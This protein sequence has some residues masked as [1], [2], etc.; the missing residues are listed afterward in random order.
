AAGWKVVDHGHDYRLEP[1]HPPDR[2]VGGVRRYGA[3]ATVPSR[4]GEPVVAPATVVLVVG[5]RADRITSSAMALQQVAPPGTQLAVVAE[6]PDHETEALL[7]AL[8]QSVEVVRLASAVGLAACWNSGLRRAVGEIVVLVGPDVE[9]R[10]D[11][12][13]PVVEALADETV[14]V[15]GATGLSSPDMRRWEA[16][17]GPEVDAVDAELLAFR[18]ADAVDGGPLE[19]RFN[20]ARYLAVWWSLVLRDR[21]T[22][23]PPRRALV[24]PLAVERS[25]E[26]PAT[27]ERDRATRRDFYRIVDRF[28]RRYELLRRPVRPRAAGTTKQPR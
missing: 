2:E 7:V 22:D 12:V 25:R 11:V 21:G 19:E 24:L 27:D 8:P 28:G 23:E 10:G 18:R 9:I 13:S 16:D 17:S 26:A 15:V 1:A 20:T 6:D 3:S 4:L 5:S 14:A